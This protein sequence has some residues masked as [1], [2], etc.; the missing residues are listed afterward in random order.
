[1]IN[2]WIDPYK[3]EFITSI[4]A[5]YHYYSGNFDR[6]DT[7]EELF[8]VRN[9]TTFKIF[10]SR[11]KYLESKIENPIYTADYFIYKHTIFPIYSTFIMRD[12]QNAVLNYMKDKGSDKIHLIL[13]LNTGHLNKKEWYMYCPLC[14]EDEFELYG[15]IYFHRLHQVQGV[16]VCEKHGCRLENYI[17]DYKSEIE[18]TV[19]DYTKKENQCKFYDKSIS[20][21]LIKI[22]KAANYIM[23]LEYLKYNKKDIIERLYKYL[24]KM[25]YLTLGGIVKREKLAYDLYNYYGEEVFKL[26]N[27]NFNRSD[28]IW[29]RYIFNKKRQ[30]LNPLECIL[31]IVFLTDNNVS[32]FFEAYNDIKKTPFGSGPWP[33]LNPVCTSYNKDVIND[34]EIENS[35]KSSLPCGIFK[36]SICEYTYRRKG[37][38]KLKSDIYRKDKVLVFGDRWEEEFKKSIKLKQKKKDIIQKFEVYERFIDYYKKN[39]EFITRSY[40]HNRGKTKYKFEEVSNSL[41]KFIDINKEYSR[42]EIRKAFPNQIW[43]LKKH[44]FEWLEKVLPEP[45]K[46]SHKH[47]EKDKY[48]ELDDELYIKVSGIYNDIISSNKH[49]R[50]TITLLRRLCQKNIT[51]YI[52]RLPKSKELIESILE[53]VDQYS[54]RVVKK[55]CEILLKNGKYESRSQIIRNT[56]ISI[57]HISDECRYEM[58]DIIDEYYSNLKN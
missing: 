42:T 7:I 33:C 53:N 44:H 32:E 30:V 11:L 8:G 37:P 15:E 4:F 35:Y 40:S 49:K 47:L 55:Y 23:N 2:F 3:D 57:K 41:K 58:Y 12:K 43:W 34:I 5:R 21:M 18:F 10:P 31:L 27:E 45:K 38:D 48:K 46:R 26:L 50:I 14:A 39:N 22:A 25:G 56:A 54:I 51:Y 20:D 36:C 16:L 9:I 28:H 19:L 6:N 13:G 17:I 1:M 24:E 52:D 29:I